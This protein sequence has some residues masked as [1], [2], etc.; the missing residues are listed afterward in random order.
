MLLILSVS[1]WLAERQMEYEE[2]AR[3]TLGP[4]C[5]PASKKQ[6]SRRIFSLGYPM[7]KGYENI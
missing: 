7:G 5:P 1:Q 3:V 6:N 2:D 4:N